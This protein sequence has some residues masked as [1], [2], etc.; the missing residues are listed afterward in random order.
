VKSELLNTKCLSDTFPVQNEL[1]QGDALLQ[2]ACQRGFR[3]FHY[4]GPGKPGET[5]LLAYTY[6]MYFCMKIM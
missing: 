1:K 3:I 6:G 4:E 2:N 5:E